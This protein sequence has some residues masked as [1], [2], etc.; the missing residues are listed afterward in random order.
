MSL[1]Y[2]NGAFQPKEKT[3]IPV[4][5]YIILRG[6][7]VFESIC[8]FRKR[9]LMLTPHL[10]RLVRSAES[11]SIALPIPVDEIKD[12]IREGIARM[13]EDCL[14]RPFITGGDIFHQGVFPAS[15]F[16]T[17]FE[18]V[19]KRLVRKVPFAAANVERHGHDLF[20]TIY[21]R[22]DSGNDLTRFS[23]FFIRKFKGYDLLK[24]L[25][26]FGFGNRSGL[27]RHLGK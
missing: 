18:K 25:I 15:R 2:I 11:A 10:E 12:I 24:H 17:L 26:I 3:S 21:T 8:T 22:P 27:H 19:Q 20:G 1:C 7:G 9:P 6:V 14:V 5:D 13:K 16:F 4:S 23:G